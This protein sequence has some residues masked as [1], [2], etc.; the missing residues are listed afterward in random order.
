MNVNIL[1]NFLFSPLHCA[2]CRGHLNVVECLIDHNA[3]IDLTDI[4]VIKCLIKTH[5]CMRHAI[6]VI[7]L[8]FVTFYRRMQIL[9]QRIL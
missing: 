9:M 3:D 6:L 7:Y 8:L 4:N 2:A 5:P 1:D